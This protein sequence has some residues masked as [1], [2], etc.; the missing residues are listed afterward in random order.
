MYTL[1]LFCACAAPPVDDDDAHAP[2]KFVEIYAYI[3][4]RA[5]KGGAEG[6]MG[7]GD[8]PKTQLRLFMRNSPLC[9]FHCAFSL[10]IPVAHFQPCFSVVVALILFFNLSFIFRLMAYPSLAFAFTFTFAFTP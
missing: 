2:M 3:A 1:V 9:R 5:Y 8:S 7:K 10:P 6:G 4:S